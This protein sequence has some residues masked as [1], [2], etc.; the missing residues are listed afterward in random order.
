MDIGLIFFGTILLFAIIYSAVRLA[1]KPLLYKPDEVVAY[2]QEGGLLKLREIN[3]LS[4]SE[5]KLVIELYQKKGAKKQVY[6]EYERYAKFL[7][8]LNLFNT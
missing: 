6:E 7:N 1:V 4:P 5:F 3:V 2:K 8:E